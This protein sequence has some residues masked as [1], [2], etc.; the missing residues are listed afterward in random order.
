MPASRN[1]SNIMKTIGLLLNKIYDKTAP[2][3][4]EC[5]RNALS[6]PDVQVCVFSNK[7]MN[8]SDANACIMS[9]GTI[10]NFTGDIICFNS[11]DALLCLK[12]RSDINVKY[13]LHEETV[14]NITELLAY[15]GRI[16]F[17]VV[18]EEYKKY[19]N[20]IIEDN[21]RTVSEYVDDKQ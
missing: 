17:L 8:I 13:C 19:T 16:E 18:T 3:A 7:T 1:E 14:Q 2:I 15:Y 10:V 11:D 6:K 20:M 9:V 21:L 4:G 12:S 5:L